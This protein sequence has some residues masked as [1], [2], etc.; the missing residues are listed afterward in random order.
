MI[1]AMLKPFFKKFIGLF[2]SMVFVS[3]LSVGLLS[4]FGSCMINVKKEYQNF[5][6][7]Y[8]DMDEQIT[9]GFHSRNNLVE[10]VKSVD[11]VKE[12]DARL[13]IDCYLYKENEDRTIVSRVFTY[14]QNTKKI[15][16]TFHFCP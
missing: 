12:V 15:I 16:K 7:E 4:C 1:K 8:Q 9:T 6:A 10:I 13:A 3:M 11:G 2:I 5:V 14:N